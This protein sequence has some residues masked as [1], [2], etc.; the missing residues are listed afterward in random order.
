M[1]DAEHAMMGSMNEMGWRHARHVVA[2]VALGAA[3][4]G[5]Q[6]PVDPG[7]VEALEHRGEQVVPH[8]EPAAVFESKPAAARTLPP[9]E[10]P[11][12]QRLVQGYQRAGAAAGTAVVTDERL[13]RAMTDL[14]RALDDGED[15][16]SE[17]VE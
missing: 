7:A 10:D 17:T 5:G 9:L 1:S 14:A 3:W 16:R 15:P 8:D 2:L 4:G 12:R 6:R 13:D 11:L